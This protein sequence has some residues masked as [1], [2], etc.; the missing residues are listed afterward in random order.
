MELNGKNF[1]IIGDSYSTYKGCIPEGYAFYY[2][3]EGDPTNVVCKMERNETW[4]QRIIDND[5]AN[6]V[7][8]DSWSGSTICNTGYGGDCSKINSFIF[9]FERM[10]KNGFF[11]DKKIDVLFVFGG[12]N[13]SWA[14]A[15]F[16]DGTLKN[17]SESDLFCVFPA[18]NYLM[19]RVKEVLPFTDIYFI[20]NTNIKPEIANHIKSQSKI[21]G[22]NY[23]ELCNIEKINGHPTPNGMESIYK[24]IINA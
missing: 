9:R 17:P 2:S 13:D 12:T 16:G 6:L 3:K 24:Q 5:G 23:I 22:V 15:P 14:D 11:K 19:N 1:M 18:V 7:F 8:N 4:W 20:I 21:S 10:V